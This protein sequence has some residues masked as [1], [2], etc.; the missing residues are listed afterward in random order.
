MVRLSLIKSFSKALSVDSM[1]ISGEQHSAITEE[2]SKT[3]VMSNGS[4]L[5]AGEHFLRSYF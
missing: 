3:R 1:D 4:E 5:K 2:I